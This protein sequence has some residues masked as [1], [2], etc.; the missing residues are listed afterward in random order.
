MNRKVVE[1]GLGSGLGIVTPGRCHYSAFDIM[2][3]CADLFL[4]LRRLPVLGTAVVCGLLASCGNKTESP[5]LPPAP[6]TNAAPAAAALSPELAKLVGQWERPDGG[7]VL[8]I[9]S[10]DASGKV[11]AAYFNPNP[12]NVSR[13]AAWR[14]KGASKIVVELNDVGYPGCTYTLE[15]N[16]QSDQLFGQYFQA[17]QQQTYEVVF[18]RLK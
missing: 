15:H 4:H 3:T 18:T 10:I 6:R 11:E 8:D 7:Y 16:P 5:P 12:I 14:D 17:A 1:N 13:A 9:K 2:K